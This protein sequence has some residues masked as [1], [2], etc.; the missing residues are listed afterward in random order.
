MFN[1]FHRISLPLRHLAVALT[2]AS[3][4]L[5]DCPV[6]TLTGP[7][8]IEQLTGHVSAFADP[9]WTVTPESAVTTDAGRFQTSATGIVDFGY[10]P[11]HVW[12]RLCLQNATDIADWRFYAHENFFQ[13]FAVYIL[14]A[15]GRIDTA[16][17]L[18]P[19]SPFAARPIADPQMV[20]PLNLAPGESV[21]L[22]MAYASGG[23][24]QID[25]SVQTL[26]S[27][28]A[29]KAAKTAKDFFFY[30][31]MMLLIAVAL[32]ALVLLRHA[33]F[34][35]Y[36]AYA[37]SALLFVMHE[38]GVAFQ[39]LWPA[40]PAFNGV[41]S[42]FVGSSLIVSG[43][44]YARVF[45]KTRERHPWID[46]LL[47]ALI[48]GTILL[49]AAL[50][51]PALQLLKK[52]LVMMSLL[53]FLTF[54]VSGVWS[55]L[56]GHKEVRFYMLAWLGVMLSSLLMNLRHIVGLEIPQETVHDSMRAVMVL[57]AMM[58]GLAI[59]DRYNQLRRSRQVAMQQNLESARHRLELNQRLSD[60]TERHDEAVRQARSRDGHIQNL[61]HDLRQP[62]H[63]LRLNVMSLTDTPQAQ[64]ERMEAAF[65]YLEGLIGQ[66]LETAPGPPPGAG[67]RTEDDALGVQQILAAIREMFAAD[68]AAKGL[69]LRLVP[70]SLDAPVDALV[71]T[72]IVSNLVSNAI[73]YTDTGGVLIGTRRRG[74]TVRIEVH[75]TGPGLS[76]ADFATACQR[77]VRLDRDLSRAVGSGLGLAIAV[78]LADRHGLRLE[79]CPAR[80]GGAGI[81]LVIPA[82]KG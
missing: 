19:D 72:R 47:F 57:D 17:D 77:A 78:D 52:L 30:G 33:I 61:V 65:A 71:L 22:L 25:F 24:T 59:A 27:F 40:L 70:S 58:M 26:D 43:A 42:V 64:P 45:L 12:M 11:A 44:A 36:C 34:L 46:R 9:D 69:S 38:D 7:A 76:A 29:I 41:A 16:I 4:A 55:Y 63:A 62:L 6:L 50:F 60:L 75:D 73:K 15:D 18:R 3:P 68:A 74:T 5:A 66:H 28:L 48:A 13:H 21:T 49:D 37:A 79:R 35:A 51:L 2:L 32:I 80:R 8:D 54:T 81:A 31:M 10:T 82:A 39:F 67:T 23:S 1:L 20:A 14:R 56:K 53:A